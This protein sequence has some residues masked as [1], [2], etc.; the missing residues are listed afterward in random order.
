MQNNKWNN[1]WKTIELFFHHSKYCFSQK[2]GGWY[3]MDILKTWMTGESSEC[4]RGWWM[5]WFLV[6]F[7]MNDERMM[8]EKIN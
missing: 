6:V 3:I 7:Q 2:T 5:L 1:Y 4:W 8:I